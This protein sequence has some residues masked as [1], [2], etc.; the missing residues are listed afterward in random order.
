MWLIRH[1]FIRPYHVNEE[2]KQILDNEMKGMC[3]L[4]Y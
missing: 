4:V 1:H 2:V 3:H